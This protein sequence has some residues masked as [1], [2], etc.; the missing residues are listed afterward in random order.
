MDNRLLISCHNIIAGNL[1][2]SYYHET[3]QQYRLVD[4]FLINRLS[5]RQVDL[6]EYTVVDD[7]VNLSG[8]LPI[9]VKIDLNFVFLTQTSKTDDNLHNQCI[10]F[11]RKCCNKQDYY[12]VT[13]LLCNSKICQL[14]SNIE[15]LKENDHEVFHKLSTVI[16]Y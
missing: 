3:L 12:D 15:L 5:D 16:V 13:G 14:Y 7:A 1:N 8:H 2:S 9:N 4:Y 11:D 6:K 10:Q